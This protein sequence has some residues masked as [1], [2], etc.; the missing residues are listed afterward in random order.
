MRR[1]EQTSTKHCINVMQELEKRPYNYTQFHP[2]VFQKRHYLMNGGAITFNSK[3]TLPLSPNMTMP[4]TFTDA[5]LCG[6][7]SGAYRAL[8]MRRPGSHDALGLQV[9][10][11][12]VAYFN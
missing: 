9:M 3:F 2:L 4:K 8:V 10:L 12:P 1:K 7:P 11:I 5:S 6:A